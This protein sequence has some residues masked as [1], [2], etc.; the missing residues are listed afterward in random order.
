MDEN[1]TRFQDFQKLNLLKLRYM[2]F[3]ESN[4]VLDKFYNNKLTNNNKQQNPVDFHDKSFCGKW[5]T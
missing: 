1:R 3:W 4:T 2:K 5:V